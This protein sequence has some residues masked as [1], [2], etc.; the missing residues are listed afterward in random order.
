MMIDRKQQNDLV[1][2]YTVDVTDGKAINGCS[3]SIFFVSANNPLVAFY[4][5]QGRNGLFCFW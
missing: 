2:S 1:M 4:D 5:I 3:L